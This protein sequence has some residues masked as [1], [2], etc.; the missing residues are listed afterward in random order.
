MNNLPPFRV[1]VAILLAVMCGSAPGVASPVDIA[2][3]VADES[4]HPFEGAAVELRG[5][6]GETIARTHSDTRGRFVIASA[7][8]AGRYTVVASMSGFDPG[9][10]NVTMPSSSDARLALVLASK[11]TET[12]VVSAQRVDGPGVTLSGSSQYGA[13]A[14]DINDLPSGADTALTDVLAQMPGVAIDQNQQIHIRDTEGPQFQYQINGVMVPLD[15]NTNPPFVSM[16]NPQFIKQMDLFTGV[17]PSRY[18]YATGG[19]VDIQ[20]K[21]GCSDPGGSVTM[22]AGQRG[23]LEPSIEYGGCDDKL[24]YYVSA[25]YDQSNTAFSSATPGPNP[26][27]DQTN[28]GQ[29]F[30]F[31]AYALDSSTSLSVILSAAGSDNQ[32]PNV[33]GLA[34]EFVLSGAVDPPSSTINSYLNFRDALGIASLQGSLGQSLTYQLSY[35]AHSITEEFRPDDVGELIYQGVAS[36][37]SHDDADNTLQGDVDWTTG[38]HDVSGG[39]YL[40]DYHVVADDSSL[41]FPINPVTQQPGTTPIMVVNNARATNMLGGIYV[42]D[43]WQIDERWRL[44]MGVRWDDLTGFTHHNQFDP[45]VNLSWLATPDTTLHGGF[46]RYMQVPSFLG[47]SPTAQ[48]A[49]ADTTGEG[50]PGIATPLTEDDDVWDAGL[51]HSFSQAITLSEDNYYEMTHHYLDTGQFGAVPIFAP[52]NYG[53]GYMWGNE[54]ALKYRD[55]SLSAYA[56]L[57]VGRN[58]QTGV[59][60]GQFNFDPHELAYIDNHYIVLDHQ[61]L[62]GVGAGATYD[63]KP[64][65]FSVDATYSS[66][67]RAGFADLEQLPTVI[68]VNLGVQRGFD[69]PGVGEVVDRIVVINAFDRVN[70][71]RP[72]EGIGIFQSAYG[73]RLTV[74]DSL[75]IPL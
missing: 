9:S 17:L 43:L 15:I 33:P 23:T 2:G 28:N 70:L 45:A 19:V 1:A 31:F 44:N 35:S 57:T 60:T 30:G 22:F 46:A 39:F 21:D 42:D 20:T 65:R 24:S 4:G 67:L 56:N 69:I 26:I 8:P 41:V 37:A 13:S 12:V 14:Q 10:A 47:I 51:V 64:W 48:A 34:P 18:S 27:H 7:V 53:R 36:T 66:G 3:T 74:Y 62:F 29:A 5:G 40:G 58:M 55:D 49:F 50:P 59:V 61:P 68:Q 25:L 71:I 72:A 54:L 16:I 6:D 63:W 73:P 52:F 38:A 32:L 75:T 11:Q